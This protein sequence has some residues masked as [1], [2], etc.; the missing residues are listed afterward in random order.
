MSLGTRK[1]RQAT[2]AH[3]QQI[4]EIFFTHIEIYETAQHGRISVI[5]K[6][7]LT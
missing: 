4:I 3:H 7:I 1:N 6:K 2:T 5:G